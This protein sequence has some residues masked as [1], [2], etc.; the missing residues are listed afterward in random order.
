MDLPIVVLTSDAY[1]WSLQPFSHLFQTYWSALQP[2]IVGTDTPLGFE[3]PSNFRVVSMNGWQKLPKE[4]WSDGLIN[5]LKA[6]APQFFVLLL[7]DYWLTRTVDHQG[8]A[9]LADYMAI[10]PE[11]LR[12]DLTTDRLYAGGMFDVESWGHYD[13]IET[14]HGTPYQM[15]LQAAIWNRDRMLEVLRPGL[16]P[17]QVELEI[18]PP[19]TMRVL[20]TR[21]SPVRF[22]NAFKGGDPVKVMNLEGMPVERVKEMAE[23]GWFELRPEA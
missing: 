1:S 2:V 17:W 5:L 11:I 7:D 4:T 6:E 21:Q 10:H 9:T 12:M 15:S 22:I 20:G 18:S 8:T 3:L 14:P 19:E 16:T 23:A 13:I